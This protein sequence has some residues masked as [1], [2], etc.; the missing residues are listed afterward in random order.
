MYYNVCIVNKRKLMMMMMM[1]SG[2][3]HNSCILTQQQ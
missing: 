2:M 1:L 3:K